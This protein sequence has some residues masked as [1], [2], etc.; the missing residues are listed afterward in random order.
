MRG[1]TEDELTEK[2][3]IDVLMPLAYAN[4][5]LVEEMERLE[6]FGTGNPR[7]GVCG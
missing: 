1:N 7:A 2:V 4:M 5:G 6:P 3:W